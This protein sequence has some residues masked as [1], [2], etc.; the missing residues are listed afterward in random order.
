M[1]VLTAESLADLIR[2]GIPDAAV[3]AQDLRGD[4]AHFSV[5]VEAAAFKGLSRIEQHRKV[6]QALAGHVDDG[7]LHAIQIKTAVPD[8]AA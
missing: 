6:Y 7:S 3:A 8:S 4:G 1:T 5:T 2:R